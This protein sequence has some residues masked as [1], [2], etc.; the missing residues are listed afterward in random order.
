MTYCLRVWDDFG[1]IKV[2]TSTTLVRLVIYASVSFAVNESTKSFTIPGLLD[3]DEFIMNGNAI[4]PYYVL[5]SRSGQ[6]ISIT[7][8]PATEALTFDV[9]VLRIL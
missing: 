9:I 3:S 1:S 5:N 7:R 2:D 8:V 4:R 6:N